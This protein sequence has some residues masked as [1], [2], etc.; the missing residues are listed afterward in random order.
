[1]CIQVFFSGPLYP[2]KWYGQSYTKKCQWKN[3]WKPMVSIIKIL[4]SK[5]KICFSTR[6]QWQVWATAASCKATWATQK[7]DHF[8][9]KVN[10]PVKFQ[11][12]GTNFF[13]S[14][15]SLKIG[16]L[17]ALIASAHHLCNDIICLHLVLTMLTEPMKHQESISV[18]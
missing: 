12:I 9:F 13:Q 6:F 16:Q 4:L 1:M 2:D 17:E 15:L 14:S 10:N 5:T 3:A 18:I 11:N 7:V 8:D